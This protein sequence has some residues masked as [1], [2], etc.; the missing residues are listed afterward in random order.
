MTAM[1]RFYGV[2]LNPLV[3]IVS[4]TILEM[5][6]HKTV[7]K[8]PLNYITR[9]HLNTMYFGALN[10]GAEL[11]IAALAFKL[12]REFA[13]RSPTGE[14]ID[15]IFKDFKAQYFKRAEGDVHFICE[16]NQIV[17]D[18]IKEAEHSS[19]RITRALKAYAVVPSRDPLEKIAEFDL[20]LSVRRRAAKTPQ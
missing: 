3:A 20:T 15:F 5:N 8:V 13:L 11:G 1:I 16:E 7:L 10:I 2:T 17:I 19:E 14:K 4:P 6:D 9:N 12:T 18:Q